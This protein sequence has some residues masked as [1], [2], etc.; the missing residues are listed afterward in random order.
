MN[1]TNKQ[2]RTRGIE[3]RTRQ[4]VNRGEGDKGE[5]K[6]KRLVKEHV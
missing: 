1:K 3:T 4:R 2:N 6:G 5:K